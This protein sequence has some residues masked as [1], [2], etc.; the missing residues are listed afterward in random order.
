MFVLEL[1]KVKIRNFRGY[2]EETELNINNMTTLLGKNDIGKSTIMEALEI[3]FNNKA[4]VL[5][6]EDLSINHDESDTDIEITCVFGSLPSNLSIDTTSSTTLKNEFLLNRDGLLEIKKTFKAT[7][8]KPKPNIVIIC[9]HP[10]NQGC[11]D[12]LNLKRIELKKRAENLNI[13]SR[14]YDARNN[15]SMRKAIYSN[16]EK[17]DFAEKEVEVDIEDGKKIYNSL[18]TYLP[19]FALFQ[20]DRDSLDSDSEVTDPMKVAIQQ[21]LSTVEREI[22]IIKTTVQQKALDTAKRT[23]DKLQEMDETLAATLEPEFKTE[24]KF[25]SLFKLTINSDD[26]ISLNKRGSGVRRLILLNF[27]RAEVERRLNENE[28][29]ANIIYAIEEPETAL[30][31]SQQK[32]L[33]GSLK[34]LSE[35]ENCQIILTTHNPALTELIGLESLRLIK[36]EGSEIKIKEG[37]NEINDEISNELGIF[38]EPINGSVQGV[39]LVEGKD[40]MI[41]LEHLSNIF[42][43]EKIIE[44]NFKDKRISIIPTGGCNNLKFWVQTKVVEDFGIPW[45]IFLDSDR[46]EAGIY[47]E[48][49]RSINNYKRAGH[50]AICTRKREIENYLSPDLF[51]HQTTIEDYNDAKK[52]VKDYKRRHRILDKGSPITLY[53]QKMN[54][55]RLKITGNYINETGVKCNELISIIEELLNIAK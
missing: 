53:W 8:Q 9:E 48:N 32:I 43:E 26:G 36:Q 29:N 52:E 24:P 6:K 28:Q 40:D 46:K 39:I 41:F 42:K 15:V 44:Q 25:D 30:H 14:K 5:E 31:P 17:I 19:V 49:V 54:F 18:E 35:K 21:A 37:S 20:A 55:E 45:A 1:K 23:L 12:L 10:V 13:D 11:S 33:I 47:T 34:E 38:P 22:E 3:F 27:F 51:D 4:V 7:T 16:F 50:I 2:K